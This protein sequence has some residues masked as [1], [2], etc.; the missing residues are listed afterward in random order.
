MK[1]LVIFIMCVFISAMF[2]ACKSEQ[3]ELCEQNVQYGKK[4]I[5]IADSYIEYEVTP[6]EA[7]ELIDVLEQRTPEL[8]DFEPG[9][10][11]YFAASELQNCTAEISLALNRDDFSQSSESYNEI[12]V[13]RNTVADLIGI[14]RR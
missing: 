6:K 3:N 8:D 10:D 4:L 12:L 2:T 11:D 13:S 9:T 1:K 14:E 7:K 5:D